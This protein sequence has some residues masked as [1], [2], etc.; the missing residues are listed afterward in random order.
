VKPPAARAAITGTTK[1][2]LLEI[3][4][5]DL[6]EVTKLYTN[7]AKPAPRNAPERGTPQIYAISAVAVKQLNIICKANS[8]PFPVGTLS[9]TL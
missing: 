1:A 7:V 5:G 2:P 6:P 4:I 9:F 3:N 8:N